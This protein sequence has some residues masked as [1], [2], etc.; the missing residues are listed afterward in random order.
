[1]ILKFE[2]D[3]S[4][5]VID[6][7][8]SHGYKSLI[9]LDSQYAYLQTVP[10]GQK[11]SE[12]LSRLRYVHEIKK[13]GQI[14][15]LQSDSLGEIAVIS[16]ENMDI[17][18]N[19][20]LWVVNIAHKMKLAQI[21]TKEFKIVSFLTFSHKPFLCVSL[22]NGVSF[23]D[24]DLPRMKKT[25]KIMQNPRMMITL[26]DCNLDTSTNSF[27]TIPYFVNLVTNGSRQQHWT[28]EPE[29]ALTKPLGMANNQILYMTSFFNQNAILE[30]FKRSIK[31][32]IS[33]HVD[34]CE[35]SKEGF[36]LL[37][38]TVKKQLLLINAFNGDNLFE[39]YDDFLRTSP[40]EMAGLSLSTKYV[41]VIDKN[42]G[43]FAVNL[44]TEERNPK[45]ISFASMINSA[46]PKQKLSVI[47]KDQFALN[48]DNT[49]VIHAFPSMQ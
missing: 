1:M 39:V 13:P 37:L 4:N 38:L 5:R 46:G 19:Y 33:S 12:N 3:N 16:E 24:I 32:S 10:S 27:L 28:R 26:D 34:Q 25:P 21:R 36:F 30:G 44:K 17:D 9:V 31:F 8:F 47:E 6:Y 42:G 7:D 41:L 22:Q 15:A 14:R 43:V 2:T 11:G 18:M 29:L 35:L 23:W 20:C 40:F 49:I 45:A 48:Y